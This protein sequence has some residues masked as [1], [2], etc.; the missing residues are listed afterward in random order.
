[1]CFALLMLWD[2]WPV[3]LLGCLR[4]ASSLWS[5]DPPSVLSL[6]FVSERL[7]IV[8]MVASSSGLPLGSAARRLHPFVTS[9]KRVR[10]F[11]LSSATFVFFARHDSAGLCDQRH[12]L[13]RVVVVMAFLCSHVGVTSASRRTS[14]FASPL[15]LLSGGPESFIPPFRDVL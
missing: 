13:S 7:A 15:V 5:G 11:F 9:A 1:M 12:C 10:V 2:G 14:C 6:V 3:G 8:R 4:E